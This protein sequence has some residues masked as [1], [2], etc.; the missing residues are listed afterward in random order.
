[1]S[2][3]R[4]RVADYL[5]YLAVRLLVCVLQALSVECCRSLARGLAWLVYHLDRRHRLAAHDNLR[6][7]FADQLSERERDALVR[8]VYCHFCTLLVEI[9][10][11]PRRLHPHN[12]RRH[13][14]LFG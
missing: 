2:K 7:A 13:L 9:V 11:V 1:M 6:H 14:A 10:H 5:V 12:W 4:S 3:P 8:S